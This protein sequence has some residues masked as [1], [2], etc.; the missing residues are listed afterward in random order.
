MR[1]EIPKIIEQQSID[2]WLDR[3]H[4]DEDRTVERGPHS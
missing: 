1:N 4:E 2:D 3:P